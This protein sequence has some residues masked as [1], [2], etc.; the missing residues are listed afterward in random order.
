MR[1]AGDGARFEGRVQRLALAVAQVGADA[2]AL[3]ARVPAAQ[4]EVAR[5]NV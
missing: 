1:Q 2:H 3:D 5:R 4:R